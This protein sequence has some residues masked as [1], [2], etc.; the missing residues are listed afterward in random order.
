MKNKKIFDLVLL[1]MFFAIIALLTFSPLG[2]WVLPAPL[3]AFTVVHI[4]VLVGAYML[5]IKKG[6]ILGLFFGLSSLYNVSRGGAADITFIYPWVSILPRIIFGFM[7]GVCFY[8]AKKIAQGNKKKLVFI[9][10]IAAFCATFFFH[11]WIVFIPYLPTYCF[12]VQDIPLDFAMFTTGVTIF[13]T[14]GLIEGLAAALI[15]TPICF[16]LMQASQRNG[17]KE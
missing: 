9:L 17:V 12:M 7:A 3:P 16:A 11:T 10:P 8:F 2:F 5:G 1:S 13:A 15:V 6:A 4:P 14:S